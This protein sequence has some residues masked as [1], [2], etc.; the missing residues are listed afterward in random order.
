MTTVQHINLLD[1]ALRPGR[2]RFSSVDGLRALGA[3]GI[4]IA[5]LNGGLRVAASREAADAR[6]AQQQLTALQAGSSHATA[7][8]AGAPSPDELVTLQRHY[9]ST[10]QVF[11]A[12]Q[13]GAAGTVQG[14]SPYLTALAR[15]S[16]NL[17]GH[18]LWIT[19]LAVA[20]DGGGLDLQGRMTDPRALPEYLNHL[21]GEPLFRGR[22][23]AQV[24][25]RALP[26][27]GDLE[28][29]AAPG[30]TLAAGV[31]EF[32]LHATPTGAPL[33]AGSLASGGVR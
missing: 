9:A 27:P 12:I 1:E 29:G 13:S 26:L 17:G 19:D 15:Q 10:Q 7:A 5:L 31:T 4:V 21:N 11:G 33:A 22:A 20:A 23:F 14:Y 6:A 25:L 18:A 30:D 24:S 32:V 8:L 3:L 28:A 16:Q 2:A